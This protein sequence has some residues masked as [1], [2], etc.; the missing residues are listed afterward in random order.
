MRSPLT[1]RAE[2]FDS[3]APLLFRAADMLRLEGVVAAVTQD[4]MSLALL[5]RHE[6]ILDHYGKILVERLRAVAPEIGIEIYFPASAEALLA[7]F[8]AALGD[9]TVQQAME[10]N[11]PI[12]P[13][14]IWIV[15]DASA[16]PDHEIQ[17]LARLVQHFPGANIRVVM[18][19]PQGSKKQ[20]LLISFGRRILNWEIDPPTPEQADIMLAQAQVQGGEGAV[21]ALLQKIAV[22]LSAPAKQTQDGETQEEPPL[23]AATPAAPPAPVAPVVVAAPPGEAAS[24]PAAKPKASRSWMPWFLGIGS[25]FLVSAASVAILHREAVVAWLG[26]TQQMEAPP[27]AEVPP[28]PASGPSTVVAAA[29]VTNVIV[30]DG[31]S[32][33]ASSASAVSAS[34]APAPAT[35]PVAAVPLPERAAPSEEVVIAPAQIRAGQSWVQQMPA[36]TF[37]VQHVIVPSYTEANQWMQAH[38][39]LKRAR[40][41]AFYLPNDSNT[42]YCVVSGPFESLAQASAY[43]QNPNVPRGSQVRSARYMKEQFTSESANAY[44]EKRQE[45]RR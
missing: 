2:E 34:P 13:P 25:L 14:K 40:L 11:V 6:A 10:A 7:R 43:V 1:S 29:P 9:Y 18:L 5:S 45:N 20:K 37:L 4:G 15:H 41:V 26:G 17:L 12:A 36:G 16:L 21:R 3:R 8:N 23:F 22:P 32:A 38:S 42:Q 35:A 19:L 28:A 44:A 33:A 31:A 27:A 24:A 39:N 30:T